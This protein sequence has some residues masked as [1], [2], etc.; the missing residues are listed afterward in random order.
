MVAGALQYPLL[1]LWFSNFTFALK[2]LI[3]SMHGEGGDR[4]SCSDPCIVKIQTPKDLLQWNPGPGP[5]N[6]NN[7]YSV[8]VMIVSLPVWF[9]QY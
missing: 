4:S 9:T 7:N 3:A 8:R 1:L 5:G 2:I 6:G